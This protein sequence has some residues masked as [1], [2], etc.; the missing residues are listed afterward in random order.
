MAPSLHFKQLHSAGTDGVQP[1]VLVCVHSLFTSSRFLEGLAQKYIDDAASATGKPWTAV[2]LDSR[3]HGQS[4]GLTGLGPPHSVDSMTADVARTLAEGVH[5][6]RWGPPEVLLGHSIGGLIVLE[7][8]QQLGRAAEQGGP[9][10][11]LALG[12]WVLDSRVL[13][14][15]ADHPMLGEVQGLLSAILSVPQPMPSP[16]DM[17]RAVA[18][19]LASLG[20]PEAP[21]WLP[22]LCAHF[23]K[24]DPS[25]GVTGGTG[26]GGG[27]V[28]QFDASAYPEL[29][30]SFA[31]KDYSALLDAPP[32][33]CCLHLVRAAACSMWAADGQ[34]ELAFIRERQAAGRAVQ[35]HEV[36]V[37]THWLPL[38]HEAELLAAMCGELAALK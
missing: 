12:V 28:R 19:F 16:D 25:P 24:P 22:A 7:L 8:A 26:G 11:L 10:E 36:E 38:S 5:A 20:A 13:P 9:P 21:P 3:F 27:Y 15:A 33:G 2:L 6:G 31:S 29:M 4:R 32:P 17:T 14:M 18:A 23:V 1:R 37:A 35:L 30:A 34:E